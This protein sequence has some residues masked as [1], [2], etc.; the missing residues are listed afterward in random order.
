MNTVRASSR[1]KAIV[2]CLIAAAAAAFLLLGTARAQQG[3][4]YDYVDLIVTY[5][6]TTSIEVEY[7]VRNIGTATATGVTVSFLLEDLQAGTFSTLPFGTAPPP[8][9]D[10]STVDSTNQT[11]TWEVGT[12][13]PGE[14]PGILK[15]ST[16][17]HGNSPGDRIG[18]ITATASSNQPEPGFLKS[19]N[20]IKVYSYAP[21]PGRTSRHM[22]HNL[23]A[24][25]LSVEDLSPD[26]GDVVDFDLTAQ[27]L[28]GAS[29][30][31][32]NLVGEIE[33][34]V[35]LSDG[36]EFRQGWNPSATDKFRIAAGRQSASWTP[37]EVDGDGNDNTRPDNRNVD[38]E[39]QLTSD[40]L[41]KIPLEER[42][43]TAWVE[44]S[45]PPPNPDYVLGSLTQCLG[46]RPVLFT[47]GSIGMLV[48]FPC[49]G[50]VNHVC[51]D[52]DGDGASDSKVVVAAAAPLLDET[53]NLDT[54]ESVDL[55]LRSRNIVH[56]ESFRNIPDAAFLLPDDVIIQ[57][58]DP[59][60]RINDTYA[61]HSL[62]T[63]GASWQTGRNT[64]STFVPLAQRRSVPGVLVTY[65]RKTLA[66]QPGESATAWSNLNQALSVTKDGEDAQSKFRV[67]SN[68]TAQRTT[69]FPF[70]LTAPTG[71]TTTS[72]SV[73]PYFFQF[74][75]LGTYSVSFHVNATRSGTV[76][77]P[78]EMGQH[79]YATG[80]YTFHVGPIA[81]LEVRD[82]G[83]G[84][85]PS[86]SQA[87]TIVAVNNGPD[88]A[89]AAKVTLTGL[90]ASPKPDYT[91]T[92]GKL[93][94]V[95]GA[96]VWTIGEMAVTDITQIPSG[97]EGEILT[98]AAGNSREITASIANTQDY[99]VC[100]DRSGDDVDTIY[101][102]TC[103]ATSSNTWHTT[104]YYDYDDSNS[105]NV[106]IAAR[107][108]AGT[109]LR[110]SQSTTDISLSWSPRSGAVAYGIEV[111]EDQGAT[112]S[113]LEWR[114][115]GSGYTHTGIPIGATRHY[116]VHAIDRDGRP[117]LPF[118]RGSAV[119][120]GGSR[121]A[122]PPGAP[123]QMT[124]TAS[125]ASR[126]TIQLSW[127]KPEDYGSPITGYTLQ[128][129]N[130]R[131]G[132]WANVTP[133]P[134]IF[135][136]GY[137]YRGLSP[138]TRKYFRIRAANEFGGGL[139]S[140]VAEATTAA[141]GVPGPPRNVRAYADGEDAIGLWWEA[142]LENGGSP[143]TRYEA[144]WSAD[145]EENGR[146]SSVGSTESRGID[147]T[148]LGVGAKRYYRV[149]ARNAQGWGPWSLPPYASATTTGG[150]PLAAYP[151]LWTEPS[152]Q[153]AV[154][155]SWLPPED[156]YG[157]DITRYELQWFNDEGV[158]CFAE[159]SASKYRA[160]S[161]PSAA[162]RSYTHTGLKPNYTYCYR[163]RA[164]TTAVWS[165]WAVA[166]AITEQAG[167]PAAPSLTARS[168]GAE[169]I[170]LSWTKPNDR[171]ARIT[172]Y[173]LEWT[174]D[175]AG[176]GWSW[177]DRDGMPASA[178]A[179]TD[180]NLTPGTE[181][182]YR[183]RASNINGP[184]QWSA[185]RSAR[186]DS[187]GPGVPTGLMATAHADN[188]QIDLT[189][190]APT[191]TGGSAITGY[192]VERS[193]D[194]DAPWERLT[195]RN[196]TTYSDTRNL[197][198][199]MTRYYR[200]AAVNR[201]GA[202]QWSDPVSA[203][204][205]VPSG[206]EAATPPDAPGLLRFTSV[207]KDQVSLA[208]D[209]P[210][211]GGA[212][213]TGYEYR[214]TYGEDTVTT[215]GTTATIRGLDRGLM[216]YSFQVRAV[217]AVGE[218]QW[219]DDI[220]TSLWPERNEQV[221]V[222]ATKITVT[223]GGTARFTVSLN[224]Q[225]PLPV[226]LRLYPRGDDAEQLLWQSYQF[227]D[228]A[229]IPSGW[230]HPDGDDWSER[231]HHWSQGVP[232]S[233]EIPDDDVDN[234]DRVMVIDVSLAVL[235]SYELGITDDEWNAKWDIDPVRQCPPGSDQP[236]C[237][238]IWDSSPFRDFTG[239]SVKITV[240]DND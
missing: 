146:W 180:A 155:I 234:P 68:G 11:F 231:A 129:A 48:P 186:T 5:E 198:P 149:R 30:F 209:R 166:Q 44:D 194:G 210:D 239:P 153:D 190:E 57:V 201:N 6:Y 107:P 170:K 70:D 185:V 110:T 181:R 31:T 221:R 73:I 150:E 140:E 86:G 204:T 143:V 156:R 211:D 191:D 220:Y 184:G 33:I 85:P 74:A 136:L 240:R 21:L 82:G 163:L 219:S 233:I 88:K 65:T 17:T 121:E 199:G 95:N 128:E 238:T 125:P 195:S 29:T 178:T 81:E 102:S 225:P 139:W 80:T 41:D 236:T 77:P 76:Y 189:W 141:A 78:K 208:W 32:L 192:W 45:I 213:I 237:P 61:S 142:P 123:E 164:G 72:T 167:T 79:R 120:G 26:A 183:V 67:R 175:S 28:A 160:L 42:C 111:S 212:P 2:L 84:F 54:K 200:V 124:L 144:Q 19:N 148:G 53:V 171:G 159:A 27:N 193:R 3:T 228:K 223:E 39:V 12:I 51:R 137:D 16:S 230:S 92:K 20:V 100:I 1:R 145:G 161:K 196:S 13:P 131:S 116:R 25:L 119:A 215:T 94:L 50:I 117:G 115:R 36:L 147:H 58:K 8:P 138:G 49:V 83:P 217:N 109:A 55:A 66:K 176:H 151:V 47:K 103:L 202:G 130:G 97:R 38:M 205:I 106:T 197:Y 64:T 174:E 173:D 157:R 224:R 122:S 126:D 56:R 188:Q 118:A 214:E 18:V 206:Q 7:T 172:H 226:G 71:R 114:V 40:P 22:R 169:E 127:V 104:N 98:I 35:E 15:F 229:L 14:T 4:E 112:W 23:L 132:P 59:E 235:S 105:K 232:V 108:G 10:K 162:E 165:D 60:G 187:A 87:F 218:G 134:G 62:N 34:K 46:D 207:G 96:W 216:Y 222:S 37:D 152:G 133:Q 177:V 24:L 203:K 90:P 93:D 63:S 158:D 154:V 182:Y 75:E 101:R 135:D 89:P 9:T 69:A 52:L 99:Q 168:N 91:A 179:Y 227:M 113:L 43:I